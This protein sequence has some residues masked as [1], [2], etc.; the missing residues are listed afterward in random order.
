MFPCCDSI[1]IRVIALALTS[2]QELFTL[3]SFLFSQS[4]TSSSWGGGRG[5]GGGRGKHL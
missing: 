5:G 3:Y 4:Q 2:G 1:L